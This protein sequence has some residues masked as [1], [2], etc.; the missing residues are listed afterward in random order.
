MV[1][2]KES[3]VIERNY[4]KRFG[5]SYIVREVS[6]VREKDTERE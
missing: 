3:D 2:A 4:R 1:V 6:S 5:A